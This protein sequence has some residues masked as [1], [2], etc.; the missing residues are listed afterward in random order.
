MAPPNPHLHHILSNSHSLQMLSF[1]GLKPRILSLV[2]TKVIYPR[3]LTVVVSSVDGGSIQ[4]SV[5]SLQWHRPLEWSAAST[6]TVS[7]WCSCLYS[8]SSQ[9]TLALW[10]CSR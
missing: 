8:C 9:G 6:H 3:T 4:P 10:R 5:G 1:Y 2:S 7:G